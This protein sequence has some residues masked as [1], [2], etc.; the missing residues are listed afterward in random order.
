MITVTL[1][2][3]RGDFTTGFDVNLSIRNSNAT[4]CSDNFRLAGEP[5]IE[6]LLVDWRKKYER[7]VLQP[8]GDGSAFLK[9]AVPRSRSSLAKECQAAYES[10]QTKVSSWFKSPDFEQIRLRLIQSLKSHG[11]SDHQEIM[12]IVQTSDDSLLRRIDWYK[13]DFFQK[14]PQAGLIFWGS[15]YESVIR[16]N[17]VT[18]GKKM[19]VLC[20]LG[21]GVQNQEDW[22]LLNNLPDVAAVPLKNPQLEE[23]CQQLRDQQGWDI[24]VYA[25][26]SSSRKDKSGQMRGQIESDLDNILECHDF[27]H[28]LTAAADKRLQ[29]VI[30]NSCSGLGLAN[31]LMEFNIPHIIV[32]RELVPESVAQGFLRVLLKEFPKQKTSS[33]QFWQALLAQ[34]PH[35]KTS[36][37]TAVRHTQQNLEYFNKEFPGVNSLPVVFQNPTEEPLN[38]ERFRTRLFW[39]WLRRVFVSSVGVTLLVMGVRSLGILQS[40]ELNAYDPLMQMRPRESK[41]KR[42]LIVGADEEDL[43]QYRWPLPDHILAQLLDKL[44]QYQPFVIGLD[45]VRDQ[46]VPPGEEALVKHFKENESLVTICSFNHSPEQSPA[47]PSQSPE[48]QRGFVDLFYDPLQGKTQQGIV[49]RYLFSRTSNAMDQPSPCQ[50]DYSFAWQLAYRY[51]KAKSIPV[52]IVENDWKF[53]S[54]MAKRLEKPSGGYQ[55]FDEAG[56]QLLLNYRHT[57]DPA[58]IAQQVTVRDILNNNYDKLKPDWIKGRVVL[59]GITATSIKDPHGTPYGNMRGLFIHGH[60]VSQIISAVEDNRPLLSWLPLWGD[61]LWVWFWSLTGGVIVWRLQTSLHQAVVLSISIVVLYGCCWFAFSQLAVWIPL[62]PSALALVFTVG[63]MVVLS[64][65]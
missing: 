13:W 18:P 32:M 27:K 4:I 53:G 3:S 57:D 45:M 47:P 48:E 23:L 31:Q 38:W 64:N 15:S 61:V 43:R 6:S 1:N 8:R 26:H 62:V 42:L 36:L 24:L 10:L 2:F 17:R 37:S 12:V 7:L 20:I 5:L 35:Q 30:F 44:E 49:R 40:W 39:P 33:A 46:P 11:I 56:N 54:V 28:A 59:I 41:D 55:N 21:Q 65:K 19:R 14:H 9:K 51:L 63:G 34:L 25:G 58:Q 52:D 16:P 60:A 50:T 29:L 22:E